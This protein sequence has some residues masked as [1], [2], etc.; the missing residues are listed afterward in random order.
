MKML[1]FKEM[2]V[3][4]GGGS[5][6]FCF[7]TPLRALA[8]CGPTGVGVACAMEMGIINYCWNT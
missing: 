4:Q 5:G 3:I 7:W 8:S 1:T 6:A 2:E